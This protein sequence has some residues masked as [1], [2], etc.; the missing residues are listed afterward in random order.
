M[1]SNE[2]I[3]WSL[4]IQRTNHIS[5]KMNE[6]RLQEMAWINLKSIMLRGRESRS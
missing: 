3:K 5:V 1:S 4:F 2:K 6:L